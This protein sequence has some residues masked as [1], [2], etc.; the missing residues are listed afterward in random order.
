MK[1]RYSLLILLLG[2][3]LNLFSQRTIEYTYDSDGNMDAIRS[4]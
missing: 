3:A 2:I 4:L 1:S